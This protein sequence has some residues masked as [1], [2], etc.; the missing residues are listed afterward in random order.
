ME[1]SVSKDGLVKVFVSS[2]GYGAVEEM[3]TSETEAF[4]KKLRAAVN[5]ARSTTSHRRKKLGEY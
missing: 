2:T 1:V 3:T 5:A 4:I